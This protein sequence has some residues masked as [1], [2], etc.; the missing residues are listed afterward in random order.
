MIISYKWLQTYFENPLPSPDKVAETLTFG[1]FEVES[2]EK[3]GDD[4]IFDVKVLPDRAHDCLSHRGIARE[5]A[6]L[7]RMPLKAESAGV[8]QE[9]HD[10]NF[11]IAV[12]DTTLCRR[13]AGRVVRGIKVGLSP[14]W[15]CER[16]ESIGQRSVNNVVDA[17]NYVMFDIGQ[18]LH[19]FDM[20]KVAN[21]R[22]T[23]AEP[24]QKA[25]TSQ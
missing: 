20:D 1:V 10:T 24:T 23:D 17:T 9:E 15:L 3:K 18:P 22:R 13:Y 11:H 8:S 14:K 16:L 12:E 21:Q 4:T 25:T 19:A 7:L 2:T 5:L 6:S